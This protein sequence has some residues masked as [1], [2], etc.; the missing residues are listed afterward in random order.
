MT[1]RDCFMD[2]MEELWI[3][4]ISKVKCLNAH[5]ANILK[6][7]QPYQ[8]KEHVFIYVD[9]SNIWIEG[10]KL[11]AKQLKLRCVEDPRLRL[12][13]GKVADVVANGREVAWGILYG[14]EPPPIDTVWEKIEERGWKVITSK[15]SAFT[16][17]EKQV[18]HQ[19]VADITAL[20]SDRTV[21]KGKIAIVSGDADI[22]PAIKEGL[23]KN[24]CF[25]IWMW[26]GGISNALKSLAEDY[27]ESLNI[28]ALDSRLE[29]ISFTN[30][31][32]SGNQITSSVNSRS[33][34]IKNVNFNPNMAWQENLSKRLGWPFQFCWVGPESLGNPL[35][36]EDILLIFASGVKPKDGKDFEYYFEK[37]FQELQKEYPGKVVNYPAYRTEFDTKEE[38]RLANRYVALEGLYEELS[39]S[40]TSDQ[41]DEG[42]A[43]W[44]VES[45]YESKPDDGERFR[46][47]QR[48]HRKKFQRYSEQCKHHSKCKKG[49]S[50]THSHTDAEKKFFRNPRKNQECRHKK[51]CQYGSSCK[52]AH[53]NK[54]SF[55]CEC[56]Q[57]GHLL[58]KCTSYP[59]DMWH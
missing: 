33:A 19:M 41:S 59:I 45:E 57:W 9:D 47:V 25:E 51:Y 58:D 3:D 39:L 6:P 1:C 17:R 20:V 40:S 13:V 29:D 24:W 27:P 46:V 43:E 7:Y 49:L 42:E 4:D 50:C 48:Q 56:H 35:D 34:V 44:G 11:A 18:D 54:D 5:C 16:N 22:I 12:D 30:F 52:F 15:R 26:E 23:S 38:I 14:S 28:S 32:F 37:I 31:A 55:C 2:R 53:S 10:K 36:Y 21:A 8:F